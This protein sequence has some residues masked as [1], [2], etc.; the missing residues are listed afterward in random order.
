MR[1]PVT[2]SSRPTF[3]H[4]WTA[5]MAALVL[6]MFTLAFAGTQ[7]RAQVLTGELD[8]TVRDPSGAVVP[9]AEVTVTNTD[10]NQVVRTVK[11]DRLGQF[12]APLLTIGTY[13]VKVSAPG[14]ADFSLDKLEVHVGQPSTIPVTLAVTGTTESV[15]VAA[16]NVAIQLDTAA[17][18]TLIDTT[19][20]TE[21]PLSNRN[22]LQLLSI[23]PG[24]S[25]AIPGE[26]P[27]GNIKSSGA[28]NGQS[29]QVNGNA[30]NTN[31]FYLDG[32]DT[33]KRAG[34]AP[35]TFPGVDF[36]Q[37]ISLMRGSYG[38]D[39][40]GPGAAVV[41]VQTK[42]G[43]TNFH[44]GLFGFFRSQIFNANNAFANQ[45]GLPLAPQ[46]AG[47]FGYY[48]GGPVWIPGLTKRDSSKTFFFFGQEYLREL[49]TYISSVS[50]IP[51]L[52]QRAGTFTSPICTSYGPAGACN[53][54]TMQLASIDTTAA[55]YLKDV[56]AFVPAPNSPTD[57]QG[58]ISEQSGTNNGTQTIIRI[59]HQFS[60][61]LSAFF[62]YL[63][64][65]FNLNVPFG[66]QQ[67]SMIPNVAKAAMTDGSTS[68]FGHFTYVLGTSH[69]FEGG[70]SQRAN[71]VTARDTGTMAKAN[72]PDVQIQLPYTSVLDH[73]PNITIGGANYKGSGYYNERSPEQQIFLNNTN[74]W[75]RQTIKAGINIELQVSFSNSA[76]ANGGNFTFATSPVP[77]V[78][79]G[80]TTAFAQAFANFLQ[81]RSS[82]F[83]QSN[84]DPSSA[85]QS[86]IYEGYI[87]DDVHL[88]SRLTLLA[89]V[90]YTYFSPY[91]NAVYEGNAFH[92]AQ[93][94]YAP[95][96]NPAHAPMLD[97]NGNLC[98]A[99]IAPATTCL[100]TTR[101][102]N[103]NYDP[104]NGMIVAGV[105]SPFGNTAG[106]YK[107]MNFAPRIGFSYDV[108][109]NGMTAFR[110]GYGIY[111]DQVIGNTAKSAT[112]QD[113][114][115]VT[116]ATVSNPSFASPG[117]GAANT[118]QGIQAYQASGTQ[119]YTEQYSLDLQQQLRTGLTLDIGY[120]GNV[121]FHQ[122][123]N[124]DINQP[125]PNAFRSL[126]LAPA[127][128]TA[129]NTPFLNLVRPYQNW[130]FITNVSTIFKSNYNG[131][132]TSLRMRTR[133]GAQFL[134]NYTFS[135]ALTN[136]RSPQYNGDLRVEYGPTDLNRNDLFSA[137]VVYPFP[138]F[139]AQRHWYEYVLGGWQVTSIITA[140]SGQFYTVSQAGVDPAGLG[141]N[142]GPSAARP[143][144]VGDPN[145]GA[146]QH[147]YSTQGNWFNVAAYAAA[148]SGS[149]GNAPIADI[150]GPGYDVWN[151]TLM[152]NTKLRNGV[153]LQFRAETFNT[154]NRANPNGVSTS[155]DVTSFGQVT[156]YAD[157]RRMQLGVK[158]TF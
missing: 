1:F 29:F 24:I 148:P 151:V 149:I 75:G 66:F 101:I 37:E 64:D 85:L 84:I 111:Y 156:G 78:A 40:G 41:T 31:G 65:P 154:F 115:N 17:A 23:Q 2:I 43:T 27:R 95:T 71:W 6:V 158:M 33:L 38:A 82:Q 30:T 112:N 104:N 68:W 59:D 50:N 157:P 138:F 34:Q 54:N 129:A 61:R 117:N 103:P 125:V 141:L 121:G 81:G 139:L 135:R 51:T 26:N 96:F 20:I 114:P 143:N 74:T 67:V 98:L 60:P 137:A 28:V 142:V 49:D 63:D 47:D 124:V 106:D 15:N 45:A 35:V 16:N 100:N 53:G 127:T 48:I 80:V 7:V 128:I 88:T 52:A 122:S 108:F 144:E 105:N 123:A 69:V 58:L 136:A 91:S 99:L 93:N 25:G 5:V 9:N 92:P 132:Q 55:E 86:N 83:T 130:S 8:G 56:I 155:L 57:P 42:A 79:K 76:G 3:R 90:R 19:Q 46:R 107:T 102:P 70:Y 146:F 14:F 18:G 116:T 147:R 12:T 97:G 87:E 110:G 10:Q 109:G 11:T 126:P 152:K 145:A 140:G 4:G 113:P 72:S 133:K 153:N 73:I 77:T 134:V 89:G 13:A 22:Y 39:I 118:P 62:R 150:R 36:T 131:L 21:L 119:P 32:A 44:G 120:Y 94:F